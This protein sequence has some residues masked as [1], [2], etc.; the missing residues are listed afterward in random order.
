MQENSGGN[1]KYIGDEV[2]GIITAKRSLAGEG[3]K[4]ADEGEDDGGSSKTVADDDNDG[5]IVVC[6]ERIEGLT[7]PGHE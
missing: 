5:T 7:Y 6:G 1:G 4:E 2:C 3:V